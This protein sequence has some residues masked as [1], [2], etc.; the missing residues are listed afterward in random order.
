MERVKQILAEK[1]LTPALDAESGQHYVEYD[2]NG[3]KQRIWIEDDLSMKAR[4]E[5]VH[6]Y[7]L[8]GVATWQRAFQ[9]PS[10]WNTINEALTK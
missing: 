7:E 6:K 9:T 1:K 10:I 8:A 2:E 4:V 5:L 3:V